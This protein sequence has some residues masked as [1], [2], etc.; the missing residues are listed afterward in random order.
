MN[1][2]STISEAAY[3][4]PTEAT[5][6]QFMCTAAI[7]VMTKLEPLSYKSAK[8]LRREALWAVIYQNGQKDGSTYV[9]S[10][11]CIYYTISK[12]DGLSTASAKRF[13]RCL[14]TYRQERT[15]AYFYIDKIKFYYIRSVYPKPDSIKATFCVISTN[16]LMNQRSVTVLPPSRGDEERINEFPRYGLTQLQLTSMSVAAVN[17][18][19]ERDTDTRLEHGRMSI[20]EFRKAML[21]DLDGETC[22]FPLCPL[23]SFEDL[24]LSQLEELWPSEGLAFRIKE[25][26]RFEAHMLAWRILTVLISINFLVT[27]KLSTIVP[28]TNEIGYQLIV[29]RVAKPVEQ[30]QERE[31]SD[32]EDSEHEYDSPSPYVDNLFLSDNEGDF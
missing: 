5:I 22:K 30:K 6:C 13:A 10:E 19:I 8:Y 24:T 15:A 9:C 21:A 3:N 26:S 17:K 25:L 31:N 1:S 2:T 20:V 27:L 28:T 16:L 29:Y 12:E 32:W 7:H 18:M 23:E 14:E 11:E 4:A